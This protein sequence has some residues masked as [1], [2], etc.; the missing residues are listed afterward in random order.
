MIGVVC[1][2]GIGAPANVGGFVQ[3][4]WPTIVSTA[5]VL[6]VSATL[7]LFLGSPLAFSTASATSNSER[8]APSCWFSCL[9]VTPVSEDLYGH[10]GCQ[11]TPD[12]SP[13]PIAPS[14]LTCDGK[15][16]VLAICAIF[17]CFV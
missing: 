3:S 7:V 8:L 2:F 9:H 11:Y 1:T 13:L 4:R 5:S 16:P 17:T 15:R 12:A 10:V 6:T 14:E